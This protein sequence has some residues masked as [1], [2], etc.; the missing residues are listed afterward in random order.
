VGVLLFVGLICVYIEAHSAGFGVAGTVAVIAFALLFGG[1]YLA[2]L[3]QW[4]EI[5]LFA[6]GVILILVEVFVIP[7][8]GVA[9]T[10]G[11]VLCIL[12]VVAM[13]IP[14]RPGKFPWPVTTLE[15]QMF[16]HGMLAVGCAVAASVVAMLVMAKHLPHVPIAGKL[17]LAP[18]TIVPQPP[19]TETSPIFAVRAG[20]AGK[21]YQ[22]CRPVGKVMVEGLLLDAV[23]EGAYLPAGTEIVVLRNEGN[24]LVVTEKTAD[25]IS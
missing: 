10:I 6:V 5:V 18:P 21:V 12:A 15:W 20:M 19:A 3:A 8:H 1:R 2:G 9:G 22:I 11:G 17:F 4:W 14:S 24:R 7:G 13:L 23:A 25:R 16:T